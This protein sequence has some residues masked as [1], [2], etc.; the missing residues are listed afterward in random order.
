[1]VMMGHAWT[2]VGHGLVMALPERLTGHAAPPPCA[3][4]DLEAA[5]AVEPDNKDVQQQLVKV[6]QGGGRARGVG[7]Q[8]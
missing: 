8:G 5:A 7:A 2:W 6:G 1:M 3:V 4:Q